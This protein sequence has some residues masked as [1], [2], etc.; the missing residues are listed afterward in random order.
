VISL[1]NIILRGIDPKIHLQLKNEAKRRKI[2]LNAL[3]LEY[4]LEGAGLTDEKPNKTIY[5]DLDFLAGTWNKKEFNEFLSSI[6]DFEKIEKE[7]WE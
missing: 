1:S 3:L 6:K 2:S 4:V 5:H 7:L